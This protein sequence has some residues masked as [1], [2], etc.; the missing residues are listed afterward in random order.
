MT[1]FSYRAG[2][3]HAE[4]VAV[5]ALAGTVGTPFYCYS[6]AA[7]ISGYRAY[8]E[9]F[10]G[11][12]V[13]ICYAMKAN[14][15]LAVLRVLAALGSGADV[16][17]EG[18]MRR[19]LAAGIPPERIVFS[20]VG[21][22]EGEMEAALDAGIRQI[23][24]ESAPELDA[25]SAVA[26][27]RGAV[28]TVAIRVNPDVDARTH[29]KITTGRRDNKFG[30]DIDVAPDLFRRAAS[31]PGLRTI[32]VAVHIGSQLTD[33]DPYRDAYA[34]VATLVESLRADGLAID[35]VDLG[36][37]LGVA[38][39][40]EMPPPLDRYAALVRDTVGALGCR[41]TLEPGRS[42]VAKAGIL[43][44]RVTF[45]KHSGTRRFLILDAAMN[46][47]MRPALYDAWHGIL[48]VRQTP[49][50]GPED[51]YDVVGP[52]CESTD[53]FAVQR[54]LP[55]M[56]PGDLV[57]FADAGAYGAAMASGYNGRPLVPEVMVAGEKFAIVRKRPTFEETIALEQLPPWM[58]AAS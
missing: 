48:P 23:N 37:G 29:A 47:L 22:T 24:V 26:T 14:G 19:A 15:T 58:T 46:D 6:E 43:V 34:R 17:S 31:L 38:Y 30:V 8:E 52:I 39:R 55:P 36:G 1:A 57:A 13:D 56:E 28:A 54:P 27:G 12:D 3:L 2:V 25:L 53:T 18:E 21:K 9:A 11:Q 4:G 5:P 7:L 49:A 20:G 44:S 16:V 40:D 33:L 32:G 45:V 42:L 51:L 50:G 35:H 10:R 41:V